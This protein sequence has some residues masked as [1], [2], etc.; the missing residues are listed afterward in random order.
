MQRPLVVAQASGPQGPGAGP[1][2]VISVAKPQGEQS[3]TLHLDGSTKLDLSQIA[4]EKISLVP[5]GGRL[6]I[7]CDNQS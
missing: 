6:I 3:I 5:N 1:T 4:D 2:K 7:L